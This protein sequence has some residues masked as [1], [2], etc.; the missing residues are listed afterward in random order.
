MRLTPYLLT[1]ILVAAG[2]LPSAM[3]HGQDSSES[4]KLAIS[5]NDQIQYDKKEMKVSSKCTEIEV[6]L[7]HVGKMPIE[8]M[9]H[10]WV[11][12]QAADVDAVA[13]D[14]MKAGLQNN[15]LKPGDKRVIAATKVVGGGQSASVKFKASALK[16]GESYMYVCT[17]PG[18][19]ALMRGKFIVT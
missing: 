4:C 14:G 15:Y 1:A 11:L 10:N 7:T 12:T 2:A 18:H 5:G 8:A 16:P 13:A 19:S 17:F 9:G 6:T 3:V